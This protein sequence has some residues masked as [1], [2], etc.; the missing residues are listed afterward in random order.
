MV[1]KQ[2]VRVTSQEERIST[3]HQHP[4]TNFSVEKLPFRMCFITLKIA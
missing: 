1:T 2:E 3:R 4:R